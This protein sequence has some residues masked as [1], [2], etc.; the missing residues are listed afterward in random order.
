MQN[1]LINLTRLEGKKF[2]DTINDPVGDF[3]F[4]HRD[5]NL[6][7]LLINAVRNRADLMVAVK[8]KEVSDKY[9]NLLKANRAFEFSLEAGYSYNSIVKN[10]IAPAPAY[11]GLSA[12]LAIPLKFS[13]LNK[14][15]VESAELAIRQSQTFYEE[16]ESQIISEVMQAYNDFI[17][18]NKKLE[19]YNLGLIEDAGKILQ[20]R[21]YSY[22]HGESGLIDVLNARRTYT[23]LRLNYIEAL[24]DYSTALIELERASGIWDLP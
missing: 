9:L 8:N 1:A 15:S 12:G 3:P 23:E 13:N 4:K 22:Q 21:I 5:F 20:G 11:N 14:G 24:F 10:E 19:H 18:Q 17:A 16:T 2:N 7:D 6:D